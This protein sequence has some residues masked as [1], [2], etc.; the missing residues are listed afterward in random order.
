MLKCKGVNRNWHIQLL[1]RRMF[2]QTNKAYNFGSPAWY[3]LWHENDETEAHLD[4]YSKNVIEFLR[5]TGGIVQE[6]FGLNYNDLMELDKY[7][8]NQIKIATYKI[9]EER[10]KEQEERE[11]RELEKLKAEE[12]RRKA[13]LEAERQYVYGDR[14]KKK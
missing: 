6:I 10:A 9:V 14:Y 3:L 13:E 2:N 1:Y 12:A 11:R 4:K 5:Q 8:Y 7:T